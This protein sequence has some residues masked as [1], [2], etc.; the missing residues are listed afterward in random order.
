M[1]TK[2]VVTCLSV[3][4]F[5]A[6]CKPA[7]EKSAAEISV[8]TAADNV[9]TKTKDAAQANKNLTQAKKDYAYAQKAEFVAEKQTQLAEIDRDLLVLSNKVETANDATKADAKPRLQ[10]LRDQSARLNKQLDEANSATESTWESVKSGSSKAYDDLKDGIVN[11]RQW[12]SD[13][14][15]P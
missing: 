4:V 6:G 3:V 12:A 5:A 14:L 9:E 7:A 1:K 13:K 10:I 2:L 15:A 8:Q 11:A